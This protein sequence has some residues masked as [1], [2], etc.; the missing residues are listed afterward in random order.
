MLPGDE[1]PAGVP[2]TG[3]DL[4]PDCS[5]TGTIAGEACAAC[6]GSGLVIDAVG[7]G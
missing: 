1:A 6:G 7:G 5:G 4:C 3:E 2:S